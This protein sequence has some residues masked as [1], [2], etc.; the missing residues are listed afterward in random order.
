MMV[1]CSNHSSRAFIA[2]ARE[3]DGKLGWIIGPTYWKNPRPNIPYALDNDAFGAWT[4]GTEWNEGA[5][6][7]MLDKVES[8]SHKPMWALCPDVV[9]DRE[10]TIAKWNKYSDS[11]IVRDIIPAFAV[12]DGMTKEDVPKSAAVVFVGGTTRWKWR[13]AA[14]WCENFPRV[15]IG[16]VRTMKLEICERIGAES[17]DGSGFM[18]ETFNGRP[19]QLL[20]N[21][22]EGYRDRTIEMQF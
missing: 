10:G 2:Y 5:W 6:F 8:A 17:V 14:M 1:L 22:V 19:A 3:H 4:N 18:R 16:R 15:H 12:Q 11:I 13:T 20:K 7:A 21:F 9:S